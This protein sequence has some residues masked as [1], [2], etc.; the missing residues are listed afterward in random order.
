M[1]EDCLRVF[2][3]SNKTRAAECIA[4]F[5]LIKP[6]KQGGGVPLVPRINVSVGDEREAHIGI[7]IKQTANPAFFRCTPCQQHKR[8][9]KES[10]GLYSWPGDPCYCHYLVL[11]SLPS[12]Y[13]ELSFKVFGSRLD[14]ATDLHTLARKHPQKF[15]EMI[16]PGCRSA[17]DSA[18]GI[19]ASSARSAKQEW[20]PASDVCENF[21]PIGWVQIL[22]AFLRTPRAYPQSLPFGV[23]QFL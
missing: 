15:V 5:Q 23:R 12:R 10:C 19:D 9:K 18:P 14:G 21:V 11:W 6:D 16:A 7:G 3:K 1:A 13:R 22:L 8:Q 17:L 4:G 20:H 2:I